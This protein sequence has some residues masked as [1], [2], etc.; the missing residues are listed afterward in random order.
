MGEGVVAEVGEVRVLME[1]D[2]RAG[3]EVVEAGLRVLAR[4]VGRREVRRGGLAPGTDSA[5]LL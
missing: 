4:S 3:E 1:I 2:S 5:S